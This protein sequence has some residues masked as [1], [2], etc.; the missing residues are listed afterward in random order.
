ML[1]L[2]KH[3][4]NIPFVP[5]LIKSVVELNSTMRESLNIPIDALVLGR[6]GGR[7]S[8]DLDFV[9]QTIVKIVNNIDHV[10]FLFMNTDHFYSH[11]HIIY[12]PCT[13]DLLEK[14]KFINSCDAMIHARRI[15]ETFGLAVGEFSV[16][17]KPVLTCDCGDRAHLDILG[18]RAIIYHNEHDLYEK[19]INLRTIINSRTDWNAYQSYCPENVMK[20]FDDVF[21]NTILDYSVKTKPASLFLS[22][23]ADSYENSID[24]H[25][26]GA[27]KLMVYEE[28]GKQYCFDCTD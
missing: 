3:L 26:I 14:Q 16:A 25:Q 2:A 23:C 15:G 11:P 21:I 6:H 8:F 10:Y 1:I 22:K 24:V 17:N 27:E 5:H 28:D 18:D 9:K 7:D 13:W 19:I 12:L 20:I 4:I